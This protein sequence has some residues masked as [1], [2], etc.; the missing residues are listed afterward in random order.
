M[1]KALHAPAQPA[2]AVGQE[3]A[4]ECDGSCPC[5][6]EGTSPCHQRGLSTAAKGG[7]QVE[8][9]RGQCGEEGGLFPGPGAAQPSP[10]W[11][12]D[13]QENPSGSLCQFPQLLGLTWNP[14]C[15]GCCP[16]GQRATNSF[17]PPSY[18]Q[19][20]RPGGDSSIDSALCS[21]SGSGEAPPW[22]CGH[23]RLQQ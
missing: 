22:H 6:A 16:G 17:K 4:Q 10:A 21:L 11:L 9:S 8:G 1:E 18:P 20:K 2:L 19:G 23:I 13:T 12:W 14:Q 7:G 5:F 15:V 3:A